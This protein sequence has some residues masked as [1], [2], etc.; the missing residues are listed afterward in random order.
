VETGREERAGVLLGAASAVR[1]AACIARD[2]YE[3][4][5]AE[6]TEQRARGVLGDPTVENALAQGR[7]LGREEALRT[8]R[9]EDRPA[10]LAP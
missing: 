10:T 2:R 1:E 8:A 5:R 4:D 7:A 6:H 3:T 9:E